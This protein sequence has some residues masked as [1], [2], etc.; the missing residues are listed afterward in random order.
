MPKKQEELSSKN[1]ICFLKPG[2]PSRRY[3]L[4]ETEVA[5]HLMHG[6]CWRV[7]KDLP[8]FGIQDVTVVQL[9]ISIFLRLLF[10]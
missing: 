4:Y 5:A 6:C 3:P 10:S 8:Y 1:V 9:E 7:R 2:Q